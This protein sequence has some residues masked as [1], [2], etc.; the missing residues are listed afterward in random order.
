MAIDIVC[1][2]L[3]HYVLFM[4]FH[5]LFVL[6]AIQSLLNHPKKRLWP[7][8][9]NRKEFHLSKFLTVSNFLQKFDEAKKLIKFKKFV[10]SSNILQLIKYCQ[11]G[12]GM[13]NLKSYYV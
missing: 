3:L 5:S 8:K 6:E 11:T 13:Y 2:F 10:V 9:E 1:V 7:K 4:S 12:Q